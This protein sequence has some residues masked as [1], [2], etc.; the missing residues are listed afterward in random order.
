MATLEE[1]TAGG[2][3]FGLTD[4]QKA[5]RELAHDFAEREIRPKEREYDEHSTHPARRDREGARA[6][7][8]EP[9]HP[10][11]VRRSRARR[12]RGDA[13][14]RGALLGLLGHRHRDRRERA[15]PRA[16]DHRRH[17]GAEAHVAA[18]ARRRG[19][20]DVVRADRA[21]RRAPT[22]PAS[23]RRPC[24]AETT[25]SSTARRCSSPTPATPRG[26]RCSRRR[27]SRRGIAG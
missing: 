11:G 15:R 2:V 25:T 5:L 7:A 21:E 22:S 19:A 23:R 12:L 18:A 16:G 14:R 20:A 10:G 26:S 1:R 4:E 17:R 24:A 3:S 8:D 9:A 13:D 27:T 6:R